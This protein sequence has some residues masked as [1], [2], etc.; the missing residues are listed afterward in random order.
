MPAHQSREMQMCT[1]L[2]SHSHEAED[3]MIDITLWTDQ[4]MKALKDTFG[5]RIWFAGIQG[6]YGRGE[7]TED[8]DIDMVVILD[9][10][11]PRDIDAYDAMLDTLDH[12]EQACGFLS[13]MAEIMRWEPS[14]LFQFCHDT[15]PILGSLDAVLKRVD[16]EAVARAIRTGACNVY[17]GCVHNRLYEKN[18]ALL[19]GLCKSASFVVRARV[20][21]QTGHYVGPLVELEDRVDEMDRPIVTACMAL[22]NGEALPFV[23]LSETLFRWAGEVVRTGE[24]E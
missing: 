15:K 17:H 10:L 4:Y 6:S 14:D 13:G 20:W 24:T 11:M 12:R 5:D 18:E 19:H 9:D 8:S 7:A 23:A 1:A 21:Q 16:A 3:M 22:K 2:Y